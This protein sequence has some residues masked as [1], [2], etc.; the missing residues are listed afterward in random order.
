MDD[1]LQ[2]ERVI[3]HATRPCGGISENGVCRAILRFCARDVGPSPQINSLVL[4][5]YH[6]INHVQMKS[7]LLLELVRHPFNYVGS[8]LEIDI[9]QLFRF[10]LHR[11]I[12]KWKRCPGFP[13]FFFVRFW[14]NSMKKELNFFAKTQFFPETQSKFGQ[15][16]KFTEFL[17][18]PLHT[19][20]VLK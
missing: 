19:T 10:V 6:Y 5:W 9:R 20:I 12:T 4:P 11:M 1:P 16:L 7:I 18:Q 13:G 8:S 2:V 14:K 15:K 17:A 3:L